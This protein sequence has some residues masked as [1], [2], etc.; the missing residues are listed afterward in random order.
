[1]TVPVEEY[2]NT[3]YHPDMEYVDG[4]LVERSMPTLAHGILQ[5]ILGAYLSALWKDWPHCGFGLPCAD[6][7]GISL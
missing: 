6:G 4:V 2:L 7:E 1:M 5:M 3:A